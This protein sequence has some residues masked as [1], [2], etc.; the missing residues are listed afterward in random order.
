LRSLRTYAL[1]V[2]HVVSLYFSEHHQMQRA[3][4]ATVRDD[5]EQVADVVGLWFESEEKTA[6]LNR[7][8][9]TLESQLQT[10]SA[11]IAALPTN[12]IAGD[13]ATNPCFLSHLVAQ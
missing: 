10:W 12:D 2:V 4:F 6:D 7:I 5:L 3:V 13:E 8:L 9:R 1:Q 11:G